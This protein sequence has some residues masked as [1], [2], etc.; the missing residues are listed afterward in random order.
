MLKIKVPDN[1]KLN[2]AFLK[3]SFDTK[4]TNPFQWAAIKFVAF[5]INAILWPYIVISAINA[6]FG[7]HL[8]FLSANVF[9]GT[10]LLLLTLS[11][12]SNKE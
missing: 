5:F 11:Y 6:I 4:G 12:F 10:W 8:N 3:I 7:T 9:V 2:I 1:L